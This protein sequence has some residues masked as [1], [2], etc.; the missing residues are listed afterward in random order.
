MNST[1]KGYD[2]PKFPKVQFH[3]SDNKAQDGSNVLLLFTGAENATEYGRF[4][5]SDDNY[6]MSFYNEGTPCWILGLY[7]TDTD[8][9][10]SNTL[11]Y[12][13]FRRYAVTDGTVTKSLDLGTPLEVNEPVITIPNPDT[14]SIYAQ[15]WKD[16]IADR[17]DVDTRILKCK[18]NFRGL[19]EK[20]GQNLMRNFY[21]F[22]SSWWVLNK[23][24]NY[25]ITTEDL[26]DC[27]FIKVKD[28]DNYSNGQTY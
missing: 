9:K 15:G 14:T 12:P 23:I 5:L 4:C 8:Y 28:T 17:Y 25:S 22:D 19:G 18:V 21:Y 3:D 10:I 20:V 6:L 11:R 7:Q 2:Y 1:Y 27:E 26:V 16:Y 13:I 24:I